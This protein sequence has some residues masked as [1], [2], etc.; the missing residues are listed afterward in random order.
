MTGDDHE[1]PLEDALEAAVLEEVCKITRNGGGGGDGSK[2]GGGGG[3]GGVIKSMAA[4]ARVQAATATNLF[5]PLLFLMLPRFLSREADKK[6]WGPDLAPELG[7]SI[8]ARRRSG[9]E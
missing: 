3:G 8:A 5:V 2:G 7:T 4:A 9:E 1:G 6:A